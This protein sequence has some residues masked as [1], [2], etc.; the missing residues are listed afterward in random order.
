MRYIIEYALRLLLLCTLGSAVSGGLIILA[1]IM[2]DMKFMEMADKVYN[3]I[4]GINDGTE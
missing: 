2:W 4:L 3:L 1:F